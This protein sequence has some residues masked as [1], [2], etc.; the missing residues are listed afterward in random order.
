MTKFWLNWQLEGKRAVILM[1]MFVQSSE[2]QNWQPDFR[3]IY[4]RVGSSIP[5]LAAL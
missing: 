3:S 2:C 4:P 1:R 5:P